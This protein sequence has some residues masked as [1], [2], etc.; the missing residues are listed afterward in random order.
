[1]GSL[2]T[3][4]KFNLCLAGFADFISVTNMKHI[5]EIDLTNS[6]DDLDE[7]TS[8]TLEPPPKRVRLTGS[9]NSEPT[10]QP[11]CVT[12]LSRTLNLI[13]NVCSSGEESFQDW[14]EGL[15]FFPDHVRSPKSENDHHG[16]IH[17]LVCSNAMSS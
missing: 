8:T 4:R 7:V 10:K 11:S 14:C 13:D 1:L 9:R 12:A 2:A 3:Y 17:I 6:E 16:R 15:H 5:E